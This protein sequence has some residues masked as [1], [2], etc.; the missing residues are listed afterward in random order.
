MFLIVLDPCSSGALQCPSNTVCSSKLALCTCPSGYSST[1][2]QS[3]YPYVQQCQTQAQTSMLPLYIA[4]PLSAGALLLGVLVIVLVINREAFF[5]NGR[6]K[7]QNYELEV[8]VGKSPYTEE[9]VNVREE[10][11]RRERASNIS[12]DFADFYN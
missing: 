10:N 7:M 4:L 8:T 12:G 11:L 6:N 2:L 3:A 9:T 1:G 5:R